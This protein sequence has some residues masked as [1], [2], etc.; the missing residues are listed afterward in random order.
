[1]RGLSTIIGR[2]RDYFSKQ[3][4]PTALCKGDALSSLRKEMNFKYYLDELRLQKVIM[5]KPTV[6]LRTRKCEIIYDSLKK[7]TKIY[8]ISKD[9]GHEERR[10]PVE[11]EVVNISARF[12]LLLR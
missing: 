1:V 11:F 7:L 2:E 3:L 10:F 9:C 8:P 12:L 5:H 4:L 6:Y